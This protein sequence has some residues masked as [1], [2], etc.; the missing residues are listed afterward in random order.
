MDATRL[1]RHLLAT[2]AYRTRYVLKDCPEGFEHFEAGLETRTPE[3]ILNHINTILQATNQMCRGQ[4]PEAP[5]DL[6]WPEALEMF[7][8]HLANL[9]DTLEQIELS[10]DQV[11]R[12]FQGPWSDT[13]THVGQL[14]MLRRLYGSPIMGAN[15]YQADIKTGQVG[16]KQPA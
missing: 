15:Y 10:D 9:D 3:Q 2:L 11:L 5:E 1:L 7:H 6:P 12:L 8:L 14:A 13:L 4:K 16:R